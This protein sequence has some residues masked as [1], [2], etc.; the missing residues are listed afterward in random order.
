MQYKFKNQHAL[1]VIAILVFIVIVGRISFRPRTYVSDL[2]LVSWMLAVVAIASACASYFFRARL[3]TICLLSAIA[4]SA[5][6][7][8]RPTTVCCLNC[9]F[10]IREAGITNGETFYIN[11][12][13]NFVLVAAALSIVSIT[14]GGLT[15][16]TVA[17]YREWVEI[18][19]ISSVL[20]VAIL[21]TGWLGFEFGEALM[22]RI[23]QNLT[24]VICALVGL[25]F[26][27]AWIYTNRP[28]VKPKVTSCDQS[29]S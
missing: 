28:F 9:F 14:F 16:V 27:A 5:F 3:L 10:E 20:V 21:S 22:L 29:G 25:Y 24:T 26:I 11:S 17:K 12:N 18:N 4:G 19:I 23:S 2:S 6:T 8:I 1:A 7:W 15:G 13:E